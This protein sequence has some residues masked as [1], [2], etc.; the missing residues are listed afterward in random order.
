M[1]NQSSHFGIHSLHLSCFV[2]DRMFLIN[3][4]QW[5]ED[6][7]RILAVFISQI[8][9]INNLTDGSILYN[10]HLLS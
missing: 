1:N 8:K 4:L 10:N 3:F 9:E 6:C 5:I 2:R 7:G